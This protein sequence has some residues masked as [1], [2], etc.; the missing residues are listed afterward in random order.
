MTPLEFRDS[1]DNALRLAVP[2]IVSCVSEYKLCALGVLCVHVSVICLILVLK[3]P[4]IV[5]E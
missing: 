5:E 3:I 2:D 1:V 4:C